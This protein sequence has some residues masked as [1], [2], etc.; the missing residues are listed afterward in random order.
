MV[1]AARCPAC[2]TVFRVVPDQ[3]KV[4]GGW[5]R[6]GRCGEVF[7]GQDEAVAPG[8]EP[9]PPPQPEPEPES[10]PVPVPV[11]EPEPDPDPEHEP[12]PEP[13]PEPEPEPELELEAGP[14]DTTRLSPAQAGPPEPLP[15]LP[16]EEVPATELP[17]PA[18]PVEDAAPAEPPPPSAA[19]DPLPEPDLRADP[20]DPPAAQAVPSFVGRS[21][22]TQTWQQP[23][24]RATLMLLTLVAAALLA[25]QVTHHFRERWVAT[26]PALRIWLS[27]GCVRGDCSLAPPRR[28]EALAVESS[29]LTEAESPGVYRLTV[30]VR[31]RSDLVLAMPA[32]ELAFTD[33]RGQPI[34]R[35]VLT[36]ADLGAPQATLAARSELPLQALIATGEHRVVG[37]TIELFY[38]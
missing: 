1:L 26:W 21:A 2:T 19:A 18:A 30:S 7:H 13:Q 24:M 14:A 10:Q 22:R 15:A 27:P 20:P 33:V 36:A 11:P 37:Y 34:A 38:P 35:R 4:A 8:P 17:A 31:N 32:L 23:H 16:D 12:E 3:L 6:C 29:S 9:E 28:I 5:V 25:V